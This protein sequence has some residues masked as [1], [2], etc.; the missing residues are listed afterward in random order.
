MKIYV[1]DTSAI[2]EGIVSKMIESGEIK[3]ARILVHKASLSEL[4]FQANYGRE[5]GFSGLDELKKLNDI[6]SKNEKI[7]VEF[8]GERPKEFQIKYAKSGEIDAMIREEALKN[9]AI[10][11]T[12]DKVD[13]EAAKAQGIEVLFIEQKKYELKE[14]KIEKY[15]DAKT[16]SVHIKEGAHVFAKRGMPG[17]WVFEKVSDEI[18]TRDDVKEM[19]KEI[20]DE[21]VMMTAP[22]FVE[23]ERKGS[24]VVQLRN[25]RIVILKTPFSDGWE[26]TAVRPIKRLTLADYDIPKDLMKRFEE[27]AEGIIIAGPPGAGKSTCCQAIGEFFYKKGKILK[28]VESPRDLQMPEEVTQLSKTLGSPDEIRDILLLTRPDYT[29][30]DEMRSSQDFAIYSDMRLAGV[31]MVGVVHATTPI[32]AIQRFVGRVELGMIP[33]IIDTV[34]FIQAGKIA[35]VYDLCMTVKVPSGMTEGDLARPII[36][37]RD[38]FNK[39]PEYEMYTYGEQTVVMPVLRKS[40]NIEEMIKRELRMDVS[41]KIESGIAKVFAENREIKKII[42]KGGKRIRQLEKKIGIPIEV[43]SI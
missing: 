20:V 3:E 10:L 37:I 16:M 9:G 2:I 4:E 43:N 22:S 5:I 23:I 32:D 19:A 42:G 18:L 36:E 21:A 1:I 31:G 26:I 24:S 17:S 40:K 35:K 11:I 7:T 34:I 29:I 33:S 39:E 14:L 27:K 15:F 38:F 28:T 12:L 30:F 25:Y 13:A 6:S 8:V 41:V